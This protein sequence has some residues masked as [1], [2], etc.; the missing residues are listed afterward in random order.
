MMEKKKRTTKAFYKQMAFETAI[1]NPER[2]KKILTATSPYIGKVL[3][4]ET[5]LQIVSSMYLNGI[6]SSDNIRIEE[7]TTI[8]SIADAVISVNSSR[9]ADGGFPQGYPSRFWTYMRTL[10]EMGF[11]LAQYKQPLQFSEVA[12]KLIHNE[13]D[14][15]EAFSVQAMKY[16]RRSPYRNVL[17]DFN[18]FRFILEVL[19]IK[20]QI[21]YEEFVVSTFSK[22]GDVSAFL[23]IIEEN[24]FRNT[25]ELE[26]FLRTNYKTNLK[27]QTILRDYPDA[28][29]RVLII[30]G[31][32]SVQ[33]RGK[34]LICR[35]IANDNYIKDLLS[36]KIELNEKEKENPNL[37]FAKLEK[38]N[39]QLLEIIYKY[40]QKTSQQDGFEYVKKLLKIIKNY[41][42][43][44]EKIIE[45]IKNIGTS[46]SSIPAFKYI[47]EPLQLEFYL[48][49]ILVL[50]YGDK[51]A[52][53]PNYK[54]DYIG[55]P[56][57]HA[58]SNVGDIEVYSEHLYWLIEATLI[59]NRTQQLNSETTSVIRHFLEDN[60]RNNYL[61]KYLSFVAPVI[62]QDTQYFYEYSIVMNKT[63]SQNIFLKP[64]SI[65]EF[66]DVTLKKD[67]FKDMENHTRQVVE[68][69]KKNL[70]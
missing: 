47:A 70:N 13:I 31:F 41:E 7:Y 15:Q 65:A 63:E 28:I 5:L 32:V 66:I 26:E 19:Q 9:K 58:P 25:S 36:V 61:S 34:M 24:N 69:F 16:N 55:L 2:Y 8:E 22:N 27:S 53:K 29:L 1:R 37:H 62:H 52:I 14:E 45:S 68:N 46:K 4:D 59:R 17:N 12:L 49:L 43:N 40:R 51:F 10:S 20:Q 33:F 67:N 21:S 30:T 42:L 11:V 35:N 64:Y 18:Y 39:K 23:R 56:I 3:N 48:S 57:S 54:A 6:V 50:K 44:E 60:K 38:Y